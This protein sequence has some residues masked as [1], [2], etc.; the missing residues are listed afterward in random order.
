MISLYVRLFVQFR[1]NWDEVF[2][3]LVLVDVM[4]TLFND[5]MVFVVTVDLFVT[6]L[7]LNYWMILMVAIDELMQF[8][9]LFEHL[10]FMVDVMHG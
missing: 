6:F 2:S 4:L 1:S 3:I 10:F 8:S 9:N 7:L 5:R